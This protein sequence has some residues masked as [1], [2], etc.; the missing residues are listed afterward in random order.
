MDKLINFLKKNATLSTV[1]II[2]IVY[3]GINFIFRER[4]GAI[5]IIISILTI[6]FIVWGFNLQFWKNKRKIDREE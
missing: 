3:V 2:A 4:M 1:F 6:L 5:E